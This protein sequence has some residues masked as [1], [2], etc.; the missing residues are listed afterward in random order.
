MIDYNKY[1]DEILQVAVGDIHGCYDELLMLVG[2]IQNY[3]LGRKTRFIF[4]GDYTDRGPKS[5]EV[6]DWLMAHDNRNDTVSE[7]KRHVFLRGNHDQM[8]LGKGATFD[9]GR[10]DHNGYANWM[11]NGGTTTLESFGINFKG[12][13]EVEQMKLIPQKYTDWM[14]STTFY[15]VDKS[16]FKRVYVHAGVDRRVSLEEQSPHVMTWIRDT[17]LNNVSPKLGY[18]VH[19]HTPHHRPEM[20]PNRLNI[21]TG[22][23]YGEYCYEKDPRHSLSAAIFNDRQLEPECIINHRGVYFMPEPGSKEPEVLRVSKG[24][25]QINAA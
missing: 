5:K 10:G 1:P 22:C 24:Q 3:T 2:N 9:D 18:V 6:L 11:T 17:F 14:N 8:F 7:D 23:V 25:K 21:D 16:P 19:G 15:F 12:M 13:Y 20:R 4:L